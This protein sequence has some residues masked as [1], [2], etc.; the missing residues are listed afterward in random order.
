MPIYLFQPSAD[1]D[2]LMELAELN[3]ERLTL[4][5]EVLWVAVAAPVTSS[6]VCVQ[7]E[8]FSRDKSTDAHQLAMFI[9]RLSNKLGNDRVLFPRANSSALPERVRRYLPAATLGLPAATG[10]LPAATS[11]RNQ[12]RFKGKS[13]QDRLRPLLLLKRPLKVR[14]ISGAPGGSPQVVWLPE[15]QLQI[16]NSW[17][18]ERIETLWWRSGSVQ[19]DYYRVETELGS[20]WWMFR[21]LQDGQWFLHGEF[22]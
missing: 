18:P 7:Q 17:G 14:V 10:G 19:R 9:N 8:L 15:G 20:R 2:R 6:R 12:S 22:A 16:R 5:D 3:L 4:P 11:G 13:S 21:R 1:A